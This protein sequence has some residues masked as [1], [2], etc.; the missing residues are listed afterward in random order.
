MR[1]D[2]TEAVT[3]VYRYR[4]GSRE[5]I[6]DLPLGLPPLA[7]SVDEPC[8]GGI[9]VAEGPARGHHGESVVEIDDRKYA[10]AA[11]EPEILYWR[12]GSIPDEAIGREI[13]DVVLPELLSLLGR[14]V[15]HGAV[16]ARGERSVLLTG[17]SG[18]GKSTLALALESHGWVPQADDFAIIDDALRIETLGGPLRIW[19]DV[20]DAMG[21]RPDAHSIR[22]KA[23][24]DRPWLARVG[25]LAAVAILENSAGGP[26]RLRE[27]GGGEA[28]NQLI[29][30]CFRKAVPGD[31]A[32]ERQIDTI[33]RLV[34]Q[35]TVVGI[36]VRRDLGSLETVAA[37]ISAL[38]ER[39]TR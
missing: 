38:L 12:D 27:I 15:I 36:A 8:D 14:V 32:L 26:T 3:K 1:S 6:S 11:E 28:F 23:I 7:D 30:A 22:G 10:L 2:Y 16:V 21:A 24:I 4:I 5:I 13:L 31:E 29:Q 33:S 19:P 37:E 25:E 34:D 35:R 18:A 17:S 39:I 9:R 20:R